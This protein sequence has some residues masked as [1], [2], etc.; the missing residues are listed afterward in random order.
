MAADHHELV[1]YRPMSDRNARQSGHRYGTCHTWHHRHRNSGVGAR[2]YFF[3][4]TSEDERVAALEA[5]HEV[6]GPGPVDHD[7]R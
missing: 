2:Q 4:A 5:D 6:P 3:I 7:R 1:I